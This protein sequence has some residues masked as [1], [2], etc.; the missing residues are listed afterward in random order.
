[1]VALADN[2][3]AGDGLSHQKVTE[4]AER[5]MTPAEY[6][7]IKHDGEAVEARNAK[8]AQTEPSPNPAVV[9]PR[10]L[11]EEHYWEFDAWRQLYES[12]LHERVVESWTVHSLNEKQT[13]AALQLVAGTER[14]TV[15]SSP[16]E[17]VFNF[18]LS[19]AP[20]PAEQRI[21]NSP[22]GIEATTAGA[23]LLE[24]LP[25]PRTGRQLPVELYA[26]E[27]LSP[28]TNVI[29]ADTPAP[30]A[31]KPWLIMRS[32][33]RDEAL[34]R[35]QLLAQHTIR[36]VREFKLA[37]HVEVFR[38]PVESANGGK[39]KPRRRS[40]IYELSHLFNQGP[41]PLILRWR[42]G[43]SGAKLLRRPVEELVLLR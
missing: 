43:V 12:R 38:E 2:G 41:V 27:D 11:R 36:G 26:V 4:L 6:L 10:L 28:G 31:Y 18:S 30:F 22:R 42:T 13:V 37:R 1:M 29:L 7:R 24:R 25:A 14:K 19:A 40:S 34:Q 23:H 35:G 16:A 39:A 33:S 17:W 20:T 3:P 32:G 9:A 8:A 15:L 5:E 21:A